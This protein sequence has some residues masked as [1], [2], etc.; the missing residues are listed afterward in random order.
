M[1]GRG[2]IHSFTVNHQ[3]WDGDPTPY[4]IV[5]VELEEQVG[6][7]LTSDLVGVDESD[8][9]SVAIGQPVHVVF[10]HRGDAWFPLFARDGDGA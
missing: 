3:A 9:D 2:T 6:L 1:S 5:L 4:V 8:F 10:E 7:R